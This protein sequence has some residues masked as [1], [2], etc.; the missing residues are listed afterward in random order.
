[1]QWVTGGLAFVGFHVWQ[2]LGWAAAA[3]APASRANGAAAKPAASVLVVIG[4]FL[5]VDAFAGRTGTSER[6]PQR[7]VGR[8]RRYCRRR[9]QR[10]QTRRPAALRRSIS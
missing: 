4:W 6:S 5:N 3:T 1:M 2:T 8:S 10:P 9:A 7:I